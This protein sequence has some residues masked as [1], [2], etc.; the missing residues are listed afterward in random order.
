VGKLIQCIKGT[1]VWK[2]CISQ[3]DGHHI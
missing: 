2:W 1:W 3:L